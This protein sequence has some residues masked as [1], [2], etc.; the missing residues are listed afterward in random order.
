MMK[1]KKF[2]VMPRCIYYEPTNGAILLLTKS[3]VN[4]VEMT[5]INPFSK[6][7]ELFEVNINQK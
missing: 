1:S 7:K 6:S 4:G 5:N 3:Q 2:R